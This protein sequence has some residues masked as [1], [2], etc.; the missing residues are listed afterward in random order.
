MRPDGAVI[1]FLLFIKSV[2]L[3]ML[4][5][6]WQNTI[7][8]TVQADMSNIWFMITYLFPGVIAVL[9]CLNRQK[10]DRRAQSCIHNIPYEV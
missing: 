10:Q 4:F 3:C 8:V 2:L 6:S 1:C 7:V 9:L 5:H